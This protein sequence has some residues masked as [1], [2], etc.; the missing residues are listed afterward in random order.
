MVLYMPF[1]IMNTDFS[2]FSF[3]LKKFKFRNI[4]TFIY[5]ITIDFQIE[6]VFPTPTL[7]INAVTTQIKKPQT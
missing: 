1:K 2:N 7:I 4:L 3:K 6:R 5:Q